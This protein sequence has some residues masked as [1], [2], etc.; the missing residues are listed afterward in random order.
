MLDPLERQEQL[1]GRRG[2][3]L[4]ERRGLRRDVVGPADHHPFGVLAGAPSEPGE[5]GDHAVADELERGTHLH[6]LDVLGE[7]ARRHPLV[8]VLVARQRAELLDAGL[9]VV[10]SD[11]FAPSDRVEV[12]LL[13]DRFIRLDH[14]VGDRDTQVAL[15][16]EDREPQL[17]LEHHLALG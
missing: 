1:L 15:C 4:A 16:A 5:R 10:A 6:L 2:E 11:A 17:P 9:D 12:D 8:D 13:D 14:A 7:I 3:A